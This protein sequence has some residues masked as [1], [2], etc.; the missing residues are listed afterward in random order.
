MATSITTF[1]EGEHVG[2]TILPSNPLPFYQK[3]IDACKN[4]PTL[5]NI[6]NIENYPVEG[7]IFE[8]GMFIETEDLKFISNPGVAGT[9]T[10]AF[11][12]DNIYVATDGFDNEEMFKYV[13]AYESNPT[14][15]VLEDIQHEFVD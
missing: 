14:F 11:I 5:I 1:V 9:H 2:L 12:V 13:A 7:M 6:T 8:N 4:N 15:E 3:I 10:F